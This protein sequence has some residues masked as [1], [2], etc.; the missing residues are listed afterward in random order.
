VLV[1]DPASAL[2]ARVRLGR[3]GYDRVIGQL[4]EPGVVLVTRPE[5][6]EASTRLTVGQLA[7]LQGLEPRLQLVDVRSPAETA[8]GTIAAAQ[9]IPLP[10][11]TESLIGLDRA[12]PI[13]VYCAGGTR[14]QVAA[15]VLQ[16]AGFA[17]VS[18]LLGGFAAWE[19]AG[20]PVAKGAASMTGS[21]PR[22]G[23][24]V[25]RP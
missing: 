4:D 15:S 7:E 13:I 8:G 1:G 18:D 21:V 2:E 6:H 20:L 11:L 9:E 14:S 25:T 24:V 19:A 12:S 3:V 5:L 10:A 23:P 22:V 17:D 16:Q